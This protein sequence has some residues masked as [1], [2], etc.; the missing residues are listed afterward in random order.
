MLG[1]C[2]R[3]LAGYFH[4]L[5]SAPL[6]IFGRS[7]YNWI[8]NFHLRLVWV[9]ISSEP[10]DSGTLSLRSQTLEEFVATVDGCL[11]VP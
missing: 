6:L 11:P 4:I 7:S 2:V 3:G 8:Y 5:N 10:R 1:Y 9:N